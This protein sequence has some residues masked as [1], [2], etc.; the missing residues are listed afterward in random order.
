MKLTK[1]GCRRNKHD[2][3]VYDLWK[4]GEF[5]GQTPLHVDDSLHGGSDL[6]H[7]DVISSSMGVCAM[8]SKEDTDVVYVG[9]HM[10]WSRHGTAVSQDNYTLQ[11]RMKV[12]ITEEGLTYAEED[13]RKSWLMYTEVDTRRNGM[14]DYI[15]EKDT[16]M[17]TLKEDEQS[18]FRKSVENIN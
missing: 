11:N 17:V 1:S 14:K 15:N 7:R 4:G 8:G 3:A 18:H 9:W 2:H 16:E 5:Q 13:T 12:L 6:L 10:K